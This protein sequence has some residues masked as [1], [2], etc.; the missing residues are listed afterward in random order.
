MKLLIT[1]VFG[2]VVSTSYAQQPDIYYFE[3]PYNAFYGNFTLDST[4]RSGLWQVGKPQKTTFDSA[5]SYPNAIIT[6]TLH[7]YPVND[8]SVFLFKV[9]NYYWVSGR[10]YIFI[11]IQFDYKLDI[12]SGEVVKVE[13]ATD[14]GTHWVDLMKEDTAYDITWNAGKPDLTKSTDGWTTFSVSFYDWAFDSHNNDSSKYAH[15]FNTDSTYIRFTFISDS[16]QTKKDGWM[17]DNLFL[18]QYSENVE[19]IT[20]NNLISIYPNPAG[21]YI[22]IKANYNYYARPEVVIYN[23][24]GQEV[25]A[26]KELPQNGY[27]HVNLPA[28]MYTLVYSTGSERAVK[29]LVIHK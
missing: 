29:Q 23:L 22:Y 7:P 25:Y 11:G 13:I 14:S 17:I 3:P 27:L 10:W 18:H 12:D 28:G 15:I 26:T 24:Q 1:L 8:T 2:F 21:D 6:D 19:T 16:V 20:N 9:D 4:N 5:R